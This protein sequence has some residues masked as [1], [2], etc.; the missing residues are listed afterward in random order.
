MMLQKTLLYCCLW[1]LF[2]ASQI[3]AATRLVVLPVDALEVVRLLGGMAQVVGVS[4]HAAERNALLPEAAKIPGVGKGFSPNLEAIAALGP[5][6]VVTWKGY[7]GPELERRL[8][9]FGIR[10]L[11]LD[12]HLPENLTWGVHALAELLG[13]K[14]VA[15]GKDYLN[16]VRQAEARLHASIPAGVAQPAVLAEHFAPDR[17]AG[18]GSALFEL[19]LKAGGRN[20]ASRLH[21]A[22]S[23]VNMEW[24]VEQHPD[25]V[26]K[27]VSLSSLDTQKGLEQLKKA[28][29]ELSARI[30]WQDVPAARDGRVY[31]ISADILG[32]PRWVV[33]MAALVEAFYPEAAC[34]TNAQ[35]LHKEYLHLFQ[36]DSAGG[37]LAVP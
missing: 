10:V 12:M 25:V 28:R 9:P 2:C 30:G 34:K 19:T 33:G 16:W 18:P 24:V 27:S 36:E 15:R 22:S 32:G 5:D 1:L 3:Q 7:P 13:E 29:A 21:T 37:A 6:V 11:R 8:E 17:L 23:P 31:A 14:A 26:I 20:P 4:Q 35:A